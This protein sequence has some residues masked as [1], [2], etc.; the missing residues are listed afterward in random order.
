MGGHRP[1]QIG[2]RAGRWP[3]TGPPPTQP[4]IA[5]A[6][7][8][9]R[10]PAPSHRTSRS[11]CQPRWGWI[12]Q[13][14]RSNFAGQRSPFSTCWNPGSRSRPRRQVS[15]PPWTL[16]WPR[17][18]VDAAPVASDVDR[19]AARRDEADASTAWCSVMPRASSRSSPVAPSR[20][21]RP[22]RG[23]PRPA[24]RS[25]AR[26]RDEARSS[27][28]LGLVGVEVDRAHVPMNSRFSRPAAMHRAR[29]RVGEGDV[30]PGR[31]SPSQ[32]CRPTPPTELRRS[33]RRGP[34]TLVDGLEHVVE[35]GSDDL[36]SAAPRGRSDRCPRR[37]GM[38]SCRP[39]HRTLSPDRRR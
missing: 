38:N 1:R 21:R 34:G 5:D 29:H 37:S 11:R 8:A 27:L 22:A 4:V 12:T 23:S 14:A 31:S 33:T 36:A 18:R 28:D 25:P 26:R 30:R 13:A 24:R 3:A 2:P 32:L 6:V 9:V 16:F 20:T 15:P 19:R 7:P 10:S 17:E 39:R 35:E